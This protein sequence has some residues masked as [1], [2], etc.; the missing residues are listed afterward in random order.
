[1][2]RDYQIP[3]LRELRDQ[4]VRF[5]PREKRLEQ[6]A[7]AEDFL[8]EIKDDRDY[9]YPF[10]CRRITD[11]NPE[12]HRDKM[13]SAKELQHDLLLLIEDLSEAALQD[14]DEAAEKVWTLSELCDFFKV[15][16]KTIS[17]WRKT[18]LVG[19]RFRI[20]GKK[21]LG[22]L[23]S[24]VTR[25]MRRNGRQIERG[26]NFSQLTDKEKTQLIRMARR[27]VRAG[28]SPTEIARSLAEKTG[29]SAETVRYTLK[30]FDEQNPDIA[31]FPNRKIP[32]RED[33]RRLIY[34]RFRLGETVE[35]LAESFH[36]T[37]S[38]VYRIIGQMRA[39]R[40]AELPLDFIANAEF[41]K[42]SESQEKMICGP[43]PNTS[44]L[45]PAK[46]MR[47]R[48]PAVETLSGKKELP[49]F[50]EYD[51]E[52]SFF[53]ETEQEMQE[54][55]KP[56]HDEWNAGRK[57]FLSEPIDI[58]VH[59]PPSG[60]SS[61]PPYLAGLYRVPLLTQEQE[62]F[63]FR[64]M[65]Y[66]KYKAAS[67]R[68]KLDPERPKA[69]LMAKIESLYNEAVATKNR[70]VTANLRL[71][72]SIAKRHVAAGMNFFDL[73]SDGN[74]SLLKAVEK[75]DFSRG[76]K[77]ST[78]ATWAVVRCYARS[79]PD[80]KKHRLRFRIVEEELF[81]AAPDVRSD[82]HADEKIQA[83]RE[84]QVD[85]LLGEL[86]DREQQILMR[87]FG[88]GEAGEAQTLREV[89]SEMGVTKE[90]VRQIEARALEKLRKFI[91]DEHLE[92]PELND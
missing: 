16:A 17:R 92:I 31:L 70:I 45:E 19:R 8:E 43:M 40:I 56:E 76:N 6:A 67:L 14:V 82:Q 10:V 55:A 12:F 18:G 15:T 21:R 2:H 48:Q 68:N 24:S 38:S 46:R 75:F 13:L 20:D 41:E 52:S 26:A 11:F 66:L 60:E 42:V 29:R 78:Y 23:D 22:F 3:I 50:V 81:D 86:D 72:V 59:E 33:I 34:Q 64:K 84:V 36:R 71:V 89:G 7:R 54:D 49:D 44:P 79:I 25:Y 37:V 87:R 61:L 1:M 28:G 83:D 77:F 51:P 30:R 9:P 85:R 58:S 62:T 69:H 88:L 74:L 4:Q 63:L 35:D 27:M 5:A 39:A 73:I 91:E 53:E 90:R 65:N 47:S 32:M 80:E 57:D